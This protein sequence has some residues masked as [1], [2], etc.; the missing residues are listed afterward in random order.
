MELKSIRNKKAQGGFSTVELMMTV[1]VVAV[2]VLLAVGFY[3]GWDTIFGK[4][5]LVP[6]NVEA[7]VQICNGLGISTGLDSANVKNDFCF[8]FRELRLDGVKQR[9]SCDYLRTKRG[10]LI[11]TATVTCESSLDAAIWDSANTTCHNQKLKDTFLINGKTCKVYDAGL[12]AY[13]SANPPASTPGSVALVGNT[14]SNATGVTGTIV[15]GSA[16]PV[17]TPIVVSNSNAA[18]KF[19]CC[20]V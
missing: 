2:V 17:A 14:C 8:N 11:I 3:M 10:A 15:A 16:C 13:L 1:L 12:A 4:L 5:G 6:D 9:V 20:K 19:V 7:T 18:A